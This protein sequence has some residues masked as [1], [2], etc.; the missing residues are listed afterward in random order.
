MFKLGFHPVVLRVAAPAGDEHL[1]VRQIEPVEA[2]PVDAV[3]DRVVL[4]PHAQVQRQPLGRAPPIAEEERV[5]PFARGHQLVLH[6]LVDVA[7]QPEHERRVLVVEI[8]RLC[9]PLSRCRVAH[10]R[11]VAARV[12][13]LRL[14]VV[15]IHEVQEVAAAQIVTSLQLG[16]VRRQRVRPLVAVNRDSSRR[17]CRGR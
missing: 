12:A 1:E 5:L 16:H 2:A 7:D 8:R 10:E 14:P 4:P 15:E 11:E 17:G 13:G 9:R 6:A 3:H